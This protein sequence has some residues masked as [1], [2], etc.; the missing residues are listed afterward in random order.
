MFMMCSLIF[1]IV[2]VW[3]FFV[4]LVVVVV[5]VCGGYYGMIVVDVVCE[6]KIFL[7]YVFKFYVGKEVLFVVV[8]E[9]CFDVIFVVFEEGVE[10]VVD[11]LFDGI[12]D[13]MGDVYVYF[14]VDWKLFMLQ[15]YVQFVVEIFV[16]GEVL[17]VGFG[18][19]I[20]FVQSCLYVVDDDVQCFIVYGQLCY[21]IVMIQFDGWFEEWVV[22]LIK[23]IMYLD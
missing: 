9:V 22:V 7:V 13:V 21:L 18:W 2:D 3:W 11:L 20:I 16:I 17:C 12:F 19:V 1:F 8:F 23:G 15:V 14:I 5:F 4:V 10:V 6:V